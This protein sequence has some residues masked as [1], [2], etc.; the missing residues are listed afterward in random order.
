[1]V[2]ALKIQVDL[3]VLRQLVC[4]ATAVI[5]LSWVGFQILLYFEP[6]ID[7]LI[8]RSGHVGFAIALG[9]S[10][11]ADTPKQRVL[12]FGLRVASIISLAPFLFL[13]LEIDWIRSRTVLLDDVLPTEIGMALLLLLS[14][15]IVG[16]R[17]LGRGIIL[18][19][20][21][22]IAYQFGG[23]YLTGILRHRET[24]LVP[25][26][27][28]QYLTLEGV[29]GVPTGISTDV[30]FYFILFA[31]VFDAFGGGRMIMDLALALTGRHKGGPA[32]C[33]ILSSGLM[34]SVSGSAVANVMS[35]GIFTIPLM[36]RV[37]Y[38]ARFA[39]AVEAVASTGGQI[40][41]PVMG[42]GAFIMADVL[43]IP[44]SQIVLVA[45]LPAVLF[46]GTL[47]VVVHLEAGRTGLGG[48]VKSEVPNLRDSLFE[49]GHMILPLAWLATLVIVGYG[50]SDATM[51]AIALTIVIGSCR[52]STRAKPSILIGALIEA[53][54]RAVSV[55]LPCAL[56]SVIVSV[57]AFSGLGTKFT[58]ILIQFADGQFI[59]MLIAAMIGSVVLG[60]GMP[61]TSAYVM[62]SVLIA[63]ALVALGAEPLPVHLFIYYFAIL[64]MIT[65]P[66]A[67]AA[68]AASTIAKTDPSST[69]IK[70]III[71][72]PIFLIPFT[73]FTLP[74]ILLTGTAFEI[75]TDFAF[76]VAM[77][78]SASVAIVGWCTIRLNVSVRCI[79]AVLSIVVGFS[80]IIPSVIAFITIVGLIAFLRTSLVRVVS[81]AKS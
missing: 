49:R 69:G 27:E 44:Y 57:I 47:Y 19:A 13:A 81:D 73:F 33:A 24:G 48:L 45:I 41:P 25:F 77:I 55:A 36:R 32:K 29:F 51:Q 22:F 37:G 35:T 60:A 43:R 1:M 67:L 40:M 28:V 42:A 34:G 14:L 3:A 10:L 16:Y 39:A 18:V 4:N 26:L 7:S 75:A 80:P 52:A 68:Y 9:L 78:F 59:V 58:S 64:S 62:A 15:I 72:L 23:E 31:A 6:G 61:T 38:K 71:A 17:V 50:V 2:Q 56:A 74:S 5:A 30:V 54:K 70:A 66:V 79:F 65:P 20:V 21:A 46:F 12:R 76:S 11:W 63:P 8:K 53:A